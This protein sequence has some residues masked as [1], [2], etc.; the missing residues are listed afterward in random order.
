MI[1]KAHF[2]SFSPCGGTENV[3]EAL[4]LGIP[5]PTEEYTITL[6]KNRTTRLNFGKE[7]L[8]FLAFP[9]YGGR[10]PRFFTDFIEPLRGADT[11]AVLVSVY[12]NR[13]YEGAFLDMDKPVRAN[14]FRPIAAIAGL[15]QHSINPLGATGRPDAEDIE[16]LTEY[17]RRALEKAQTGGSA[18]AAPG[19][20]PTWTL[21]PGP[22]A[23]FIA[24][25]SEVCNECGA[26]VHVCPNNAIPAGSPR[27]IMTDKCIVCGACAK[28]CPQKARSIQLR[29][30]DEVRAEMAKHRKV[31]TTGR[32]EP[33]LFL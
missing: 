27:E 15:A 6:P 2:I 28:Y 26:C 20:Y 29:D 8:V 18:I 1:K 33:E 4:A 7:D 9:V 17:G 5:L 21:P 32:R 12:G 3:N 23:L 30:D 25:D 10:M 19:E 22:P 24:A 31:L 16:K 11:P 13:A 14:G